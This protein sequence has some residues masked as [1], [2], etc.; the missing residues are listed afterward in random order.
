MN[1]FVR[2]YG[3]LHDHQYSSRR[4][5]S[6]FSLY[7]LSISTTEVGRPILASQ[8]RQRTNEINQIG[9]QGQAKRCLL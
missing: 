5:E 6:F 4:S 1:V 2:S 8:S 9:L 3:E 7:V